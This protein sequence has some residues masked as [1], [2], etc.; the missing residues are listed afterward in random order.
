[1]VV[2]QLRKFARRHQGLLAAVA[3]VFLA[4]VVGLIGTGIGM[5]R[6]R[7]SEQ[8]ARRLLAESYAQAAQ[9]AVRRAAWRDAVGH[10]ER[11]V[12]AGPFHQRANAMLGLTLVMLGRMPAA[13][14][15]LTVARLLFPEDPTFSLLLAMTHAGEGDAAAAR[16]ALDP[17]RDRL[18]E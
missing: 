7:R 16:A 2:Y 11:A 17:A 10:F 6:A 3:A 1:S 12:A 4:L 18:G 14:E 9:L 13:R 15:R 5:V 8:D